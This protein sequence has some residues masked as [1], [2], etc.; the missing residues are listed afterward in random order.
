[1]SR[2]IM[3][4][5][6][7]SVHTLS[8]GFYTPA[9]LKADSTRVSSRLVLMVRGNEQ[10]GNKS[11]KT[12]FQLTMW[13]AKDSKPGDGFAE[14]MARLTHIGKEF[15]TIQAAIRDYESTITNKEGVVFCNAD[16][17][18]VK[19]T[20][21]TYVVDNGKCRPGSDATKVV[22]NEVA[23][24]NASSGPE[25]K[26]VPVDKCLHARPENWDRAGSVD[27]AKWKEIVA[28][29]TAQLPVVGSKTYGY[30]HLCAVPAGC[31]AIGMAPVAAAPAADVAVAAEIGAAL[32]ADNVGDDFP[33]DAQLEAG[34]V[35]Y[36]EEVPF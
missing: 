5:N 4:A 22:Q 25:K 29:R 19:V 23:N 35:I 21:T 11:R 13:S 1:M 7:S 8:P 28:F 33:G 15:S 2:A 3:E 10:I 32:P 9:Y 24:Y 18:P 26:D 34:G 27:A 12:D 36:G 17:T 14:K 6:L 30:A 31:T 20:K 16:G